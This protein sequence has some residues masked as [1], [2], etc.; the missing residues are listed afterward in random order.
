MQ[1][2]TEKERERETEKETDRGTGIVEAKVRGKILK[3]IIL[4]QFELSKETETWLVL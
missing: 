3:A 4:N 2:E 1:R